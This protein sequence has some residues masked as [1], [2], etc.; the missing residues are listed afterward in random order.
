[1]KYLLFT[2]LCAIMFVCCSSNNEPEQ[3]GNKAFQLPVKSIV[4]A[5]QAT[6]SIVILDASNNQTVWTWSPEK[7]SVPSN[8]LTWFHNP[9]EVK[10]IFNNQ[11]IL[12]TA[13]G[14]AVALIRI[15]DSKL[16]FYAYVGENPHSAEILPDGNLV[17]VS[18]T[19]GKLRTFATDTIKGTGEWVASYEL[20]SAH[21]VVW[22]RKRELLYATEDIVLKSYK[23]NFNRKEPRLIEQDVLFELPNTE[24]CG[25][26]LFPVDGKDDILWLTT[27]ERVWQYDVK[28]N[29]T[30]II[31]DLYAVKSVSNS[32]DGVLMLYPTTEWWSDGLINEKGKKQFSIYGAKIYKGRW[33]TDNTFSYPEIHEPKFE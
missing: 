33:M 28:A 18:S 25:H 11:Y 30:E 6:K 27:N 8:C 21:N 9:S 17:A 20:P 22:D 14:G 32:P 15:A 7:A 13:S 5:E 23:Y 3:T 4:L 31:Y 10:P 16:M 2:A 1:M 12:M 19:D 29:T 24:S 26:D